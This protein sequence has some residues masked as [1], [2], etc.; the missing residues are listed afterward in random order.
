MACAM[1]GCTFLAKS[2]WK[3][4]ETNQD[5]V[6]YAADSPDLVGTTCNNNVCSR[7]DTNLGGCQ[8]NAQC[9]EQLNTP[10]ICKA[11]ATGQECTTLLSED[12]TLIGE[13]NVT[14]D[15]VIIVGVMDMR[16]GPT[17]QYQEWS[18]AHFC[19][20]DMVNK[21]F[22]KYA[23]GLP[24]VGA[25]GR[26]PM[27]ALTC[28]ENKNP[29]RVLKHLI[30][31]VGVKM[32]GGP[33]ISNDVLKYVPQYK[34]RNVAFLS[35]TAGSP[36]IL[37][38][39]DNGLFWAVTPN[40]ASIM[41]SFA[42]FTQFAEARVRAQNE[43]HDVKVAL[44]IGSDA[45][46]Q[47]MGKVLVEDNALVY[48]NGKT[49]ASQIDAGTFRQINLC[50]TFENANCDD[51]P[52]VPALGMYAPDIVIL[53]TPDETW[54]SKYMDQVESVIKPIWLLPRLDDLIITYMQSGTGAADLPSRVLAEDFP[55]DASPVFNTF[56]SAYIAECPEHTPEGNPQI[57]NFPWMTENAYDGAF[58]MHYAYL[59][60]GNYK[61]PTAQLGG[62]DFVKALL[63]LAPAG[64]GTE[65][66][67]LDLLSSKIEKTLNTL[68]SG[69]PVN[70]TG[71]SSPLDFETTLKS[72]IRP[73]DIFCIDPGASP[74]DIAWASTG[75]S[76]DPETKSLTGTYSCP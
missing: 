10:A 44:L 11:P 26:R 40:D 23:S 46:S 67:K 45:V 4:C 48:N 39:D 51:S 56:K 76:Y 63:A 61:R 58:L 7:P 16:S 74:S 30:D 52:T 25:S 20:F 42:P 24:G 15:D 8:S 71:A 28:D 31:E 70:V 60:A 14:N 41:F 55:Q 64:S 49:A 36:L 18:Q 69:A 47:G 1:A 27:A 75:L 68:I 3:Q 22:D 19:A 33:S 5:C 65:G 73:M 54:V 35:V 17:A 50:D 34:D 9:T 2:D 66:E 38:M 29:A 57:P 43:N 32:V 37:D 6:D 13:S 53:I 62:Q 59:A 21:W 72:P 12:C